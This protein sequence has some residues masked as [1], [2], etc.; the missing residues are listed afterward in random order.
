MIAAG[1]TTNHDNNR[2]LYFN[3]QFIWSELI[4]LT[5][6]SPEFCRNLVPEDEAQWHYA[7]HIDITNFIDNRGF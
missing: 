4:K 6:S 7:A 1:M 5:L 2:P 3:G